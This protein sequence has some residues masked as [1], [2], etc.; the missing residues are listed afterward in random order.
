M[1]TRGRL[2]I[3]SE[4]IEAKRFGALAAEV[5]QVRAGVDMTDDAV[6]AS[7]GPFRDLVRKLRQKTTNT[8]SRVPNGQPTTNNGR[9]S[10]SPAS[11]S[12]AHFQMS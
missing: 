1:G 5:T 6:A 8:E 3:A 12:W 7:G 11:R 10:L 2:R 9:V 4:E